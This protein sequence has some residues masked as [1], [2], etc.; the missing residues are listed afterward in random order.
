MYHSRTLRP[1]WKDTALANLSYYELRQAAPL[2]NYQQLYGGG[3]TLWAEVYHL[4]GWEYRALFG[5]NSQSQLP[6]TITKHE[7][8]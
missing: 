1:T 2:V 8:S 4:N 7:I 6:L 3:G 5:D